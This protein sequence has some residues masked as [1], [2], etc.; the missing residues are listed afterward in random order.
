MN[1]FEK[2]DLAGKRD[3]GIADGFSIFVEANRNSVEAE[4]ACTRGT[5]KCAHMDTHAHSQVEY[6]AIKEQYPFKGSLIIQRP[7]TFQHQGG[8]P[9]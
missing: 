5:S 2:A 1:V 4:V 6:M 3:V 8:L 9:D 7:L